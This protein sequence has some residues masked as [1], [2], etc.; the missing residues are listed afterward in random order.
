MT[1]NSLSPYLLHF[2]FP[3]NENITDMM[4]RWMSLY[5]V[6]YKTIRLDSSHQSIRRR[7]GQHFT[8]Q[9]HILQ[10]VTFISTTGRQTDFFVWA[11]IGANSSTKTG[12]SQTL[13]T[14]TCQLTHVQIYTSGIESYSLPWH[15]RSK[16]SDEY[17][18]VY[19]I[20]DFPWFFTHL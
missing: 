17:T 19:P 1:N 9:G 5:C 20:P 3:N 16:V 6:L 18:D 15:Q 13:E 10:E 12:E 11:G 7:R 8:W 14:V 2:I 4:W